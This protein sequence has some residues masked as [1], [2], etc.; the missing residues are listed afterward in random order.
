MVSGK[1]LQLAIQHVESTVQCQILEVHDFLVTARVVE[2]HDEFQA[3]VVRGNQVGRVRSKAGWLLKGVH[4]PHLAE[5]GIVYKL[6]GAHGSQVGP[7]PLS[8]PSNS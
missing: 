3:V 2:P 6:A 1:N 5:H 4:R 7:L 8:V